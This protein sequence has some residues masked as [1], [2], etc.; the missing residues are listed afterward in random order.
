M[1]SPQSR[2]LVLVRHAKSDQH[3]AAGVDDH[4]RPLNERG[5]RD[6]PALGRWLSA[7][8]GA[9]DLVL[10]SSALRAQ[11]TWQLAVAELAAVPA[12]QVLPELYLA[13][14]GTVLAIIRKVAPDVATLVIV[15]HEPVQSTLTKALAGPGSDPQSLT[16]MAAG[17]TTS[18]VAML[19][20]GGPWEALQ[21]HG[22]R[23][24]GF[25]A[26]RG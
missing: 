19:E 10:S 13:S 6:A 3:P 14:P 2:R 11:Q 21:L 22:A 8:V 5:R 12:L 25:T 9:P 17:F 18:A 26:P 1:T 16:A 15:G 20:I 7:G 4:E 24:T 23:L